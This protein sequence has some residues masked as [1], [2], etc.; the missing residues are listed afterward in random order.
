V[1]AVGAAVVVTTSVIVGV[2]GAGVGA[3]IG[4]I[5]GLTVGTL[6]GLS[7][8]NQ[9]DALAAEAYRTWMRQHGYVE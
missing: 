9:N 5:V 2:L 4:G 1:R 7:A 6:Y 8:S 3:A